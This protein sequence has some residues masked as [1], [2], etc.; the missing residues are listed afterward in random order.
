MAPVQDPAPI[1]V[2]VPS[3]LQYLLKVP[4]PRKRR[5]RRHPLSALLALLCLAFLSG[6]QG[7]LPAHDWATALSVEDRYALGFTRPKAPAAST[8]W[9]VLRLV[10]WEALETELREWLL[11]AEAA[12]A[13]VPAEATPPPDNRARQ[14]PP[15]VPDD[16]ALAIDG[17]A[18]RGS[19][20][21]SAEIAGL[22]A[23][24]RHR[25]G[26]TVAQ[27]PMSCK[28]GEL[29]AV[30]ELLKGLVLTGLVV[31]VDAQFTQKDLA[32][33]ICDRG[34]DYVMRVKENQPTLLANLQ[35]LLSVGHPGTKRRGVTSTY[36]QEHGR[37]ESRTLVCH[38]LTAAEQ[39]QLAWPHAQQ[40]FVV[41]SYR[42]QQGERNGKPTLV[43]GITSLTAAQA[44]PE[45]LLR[46][47]RGHWSVENR[48]FWERD[49]VFDEDAS[50]ATTKNLVAVLACLRGAVLNLIRFHQ[51][52][53]GVAKTVRRFNA[54]RKQALQALGCG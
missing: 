33:A 7:Y 15:F 48:A 8:L 25:L 34:G 38:V 49:V 24:V 2:R 14:R 29:T 36:D 18:L 43:H 20:K 12:L 31:T 44:D 23:V 45:R 22:L 17:K 3:L 13:Q 11:A 35:Q 54:N 32:E 21:R 53:A 6:I 39:Q 9:E 28:E 51:G 46:L 10:G 4:D 52:K 5:G 47:H 42:A 19:Y 37:V 30:R 16:R 40:V 50:P 27:Q 26:M 1:A 41:A